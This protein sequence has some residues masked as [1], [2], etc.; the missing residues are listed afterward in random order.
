MDIT[1]YLNL[2]PTENSRAEKYMNFLNAILTPVV[3]LQ[4]VVEDRNA[5][6]VDTAAGSQLDIIGELVSVSREL[7]YLP[8]NG[9]RGMDDDVYRIILKMRVA[10]EMWDGGNKNAAEI[11]RD[12]IG[13]FVNIEYVDNLDCSVSVT[14]GAEEASA[15][16]IIYAN[17]ELLVPAGV[18]RTLSVEVSNININGYNAFG[19]I[20]QSYC[21]MINLERGS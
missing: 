15:A 21:N 8:E 2:V 11:Y 13:S 16:Q 1:R 17:Q 7:P 14:L 10:Q 9:I 12:T 4:G 6:A 18:G 3:D 5:Y 19:I 20:S